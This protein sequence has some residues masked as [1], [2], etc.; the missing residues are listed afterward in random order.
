[1]GAV[2]EDVFFL[3]DKIT[4]GDLKLLYFTLKSEITKIVVYKACFLPNSKVE[5][6]MSREDSIKLTVVRLS[7]LD[8]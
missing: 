2:R 6:L 1:M 8:P 3:L 5:E 4:N 7:H